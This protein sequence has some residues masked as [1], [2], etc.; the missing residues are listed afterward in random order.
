MEIELGVAEKEWQEIAD[1][2]S[3]ATYFHTSSWMRVLVETQK[4]AVD[5]TLIGRERGVGRIILPLCRTWRESRIG[6][7]VYISSLLFTYG[8]VIAEGN[9]TD[10]KL[11]EALLRLI[12]WAELKADSVTIIGNPHKKIILRSRKKKITQSSHIV[13]LSNGM[14][15]V[16]RGYRKG[17]KWA[18]KKAVRENVNVRIGRGIN[19]WKTYYSLYEESLRR[20]SDSAT[21][22]YDWAFFDHLRKEEG[23]R[24][25]LWLAERDK[26]ACAAAIVMYQ[27]RVA[28]YWHGASTE[29]CYKFRASNLLQDSIMEDAFQRGISIY[30]ML[31][32][33]GHAGV[34][35]FKKG[36]G[37]T[38][39]DYDIQRWQCGIKRRGAGLIRKIFSAGE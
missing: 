27:S 22:R 6:L 19:D 20:W 18:V 37:A 16:R 35:H 12:R 33:G 8:G 9:W 29:S 39:K 11:E 31:G 17:H 3:W 5:S 23:D 2:C 21:S 30:D 10:K 36:F 34:A 4:E 14:E 28:C 7:S 26:R 25:V 1:G 15:T 32:S 38:R 13:D 24:L